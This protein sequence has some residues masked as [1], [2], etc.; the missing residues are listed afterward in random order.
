[1]K[2]V[3]YLLYEE[4]WNSEGFG[5]EQFCNEIFRLDFNHL[6]H[7]DFIPQF[8][9]HERPWP[10]VCSAIPGD[11]LNNDDARYW[12]AANGNILIIVDEERKGGVYYSR[13]EFPEFDEQFDENR[14][15]GL[16]FYI[17]SEQYSKLENEIAP[18]ARCPQS[19]ADTK[20]FSKLKGTLV[21]DF[22]VNTV[23]SYIEKNLGGE[24]PD[25]LHHLAILYGLI[26]IANLESE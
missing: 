15:S 24:N 16:I 19:A 11:I 4:S 9:I 17:S 14:F 1:M 21:Y 8:D 3:K 25:Y 22:V 18:L 12:V 5:Y 20:P 13:I 7:V 2:K 10:P 26:P 6:F 23:L